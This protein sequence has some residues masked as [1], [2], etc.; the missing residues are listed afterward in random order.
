MDLEPYRDSS[1]P[2]EDR[3]R[4]LL[5][6]MTLEEKAAQTAA[7]FGTVVGVHTPP[8]TGWGNATAALSTLGLPPRETARAGNELQR[9]H[10]EDTRLGIPV[11][12]AEEAL[13]GLKVRDATTFPDAIAQAATWDPDLIEEMARTI[14]RQMA[15]LGVRQALSPLADVA[16]DPR[17]GRVEET[18]GEEPY[19][20]G[21]MASAFVRGLQEADPDVPRIATLKHFIGYSASDG[22]RNGEPVQLGPRE[23]REVHGRPFE[24]A[25]RLGGAGGVMPSYNDIDKVPVTGSKAYLT[26]LLRL[27]YGFDGLVIS[28]L[29]AIVQLQSKHGTAASLTEAYA[30][31][32]RAG[33]DLDLDNRASSNLIVE[34][35]QSG[36][37]H[38]SALDR[39]VASILRTKFR[40]GLFE[41]PYVDV[42]AVP[43]TF[44][45]ETTRALARTIAEKSVT[46]LKNDA[47]DGRPL[48]PLNPGLGTI[49]VIGP[50]A[51]RPL[52]QLGHYSY[53]VLDS[54]TVQ[55]A[56]PAHP[57]AR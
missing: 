14:G 17:W 12:L 52:G 44:D 43:E 48:L 45:S 50:N 2:V 35:V 26:D 40:L 32:L 31:A 36:L 51:D 21:T 27:E 5:A 16:R 13:V 28:D 42:D 25:I 34:A 9:K 8:L 7:P 11:L 18:Y 30:Q 33:V 54:I 3:V 39:A 10:V 1:L 57:A 22:G 19:L 37:L 15:R 23:L 41:R 29:G 56:Q 6:R 46:L 47:V 38:E 49:A 24:M 53:Q 4:D 20:V 55:F